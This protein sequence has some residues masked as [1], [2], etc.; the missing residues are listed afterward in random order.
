MVSRRELVGGGVL[1]GLAGMVPQT[2]AAPTT[3]R[4]D[5]GTMVARAIDDLRESLE[6]ESEACRLGLCG[7]IDAVR[8]QQKIFLK[9][10]HKFPDYIDAG[11]DAWCELYDWHVKNRQAINTSRL[12]DGR[13]GLT[14]MFTI[15]VLRPEQ[16]ANYIGWGYDA[17]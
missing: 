4:D 12:P 11:V 17:R 14:F 3:E 5:D 10:N 9:A 15:I 13:Y 2:K 16:A 7:V 8:S 6:R 1:A